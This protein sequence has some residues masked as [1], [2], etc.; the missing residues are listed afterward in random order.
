MVSAYDWIIID[1]NPEYSGKYMNYEV[2]SIEIQCH[3][4]DTT[5]PDSFFAGSLYVLDIIKIYY[6]RE[7]KY[8]SE[9]Q[10]NKFSH[11]SK[12]INTIWDVIGVECP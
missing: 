8:F 6:F 9:N 4:H 2:R 10:N 11:S 3:Q 12:L 5:H 7:C 1:I